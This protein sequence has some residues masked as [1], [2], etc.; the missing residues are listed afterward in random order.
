MGV[1]Y[2]VIKTF[3]LPFT[4]QRWRATLSAFKSTAHETA[5]CV[6]LKWVAY[7]SC[8][9]IYVAVVHCK[10]FHQYI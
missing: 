4:S 6:S 8:V 5:K 7:A 3:S 2:C 1:S 9:S 10:S